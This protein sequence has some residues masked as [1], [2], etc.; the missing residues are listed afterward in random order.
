MGGDIAHHGGEF[1]PTEYLPLPENINPNPL[2]APFAKHAS[3]CPGHIFEAIHPT[4][5]ST[6]P[7]MYPNGAV[8]SDAAQ[9]QESLVKYE[10]FDAHED[11]FAVIAHDAALLDVVEFYPKSANDWRAEGWKAEA[12]WRFLRDFDTTKQ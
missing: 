7:F 9:A 3:V 5:S 11:V 6:E 8:H 12:L 4:H 10:E 2:E 1:R